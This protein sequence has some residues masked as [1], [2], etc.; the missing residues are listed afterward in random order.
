M[1]SIVTPVHNAARYLDQLLESVDA[2]ECDHEHWVLDGAST[3]GTT[4][5]LRRHETPVRQWVSEPDDGQTHA[6]NKGL[7]RVGG[8][9]VNWINGDNAYIPAAWD[10]AVRYLLERPEVD[11]V[12]GG[13]HIVDEHGAIRRTYIP[14]AWS[15][16]RYLFFGDYVPTE[17]ILFRRRLLEEVAP[18]DERYVDAAD[19][20]FYLRLLHRRTVH[21]LAEPLILYRYHPQSKTARDPLLQQDEHR[22]IRDR[23]A[24][25]ARDRAIMVGFDRAKRAILPRISAWPR[26]FP[27]P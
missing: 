4:D 16:Q 3:D 2:L 13:M 9:L 25:G 11:A 23:W 21:R 12:F 7:A 6:V 20:D 14:A 8:E 17:T 24:R 10:R 27:E 26:P 1:L 18:L 22:V 15:W 5:I 19:Y